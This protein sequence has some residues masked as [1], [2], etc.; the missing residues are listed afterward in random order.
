MFPVRDIQKD[1]MPFSDIPVA[2]AESRFSYR[3]NEPA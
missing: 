2:E 1:T 3:F